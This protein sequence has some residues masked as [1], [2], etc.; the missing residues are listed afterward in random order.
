MKTTALIIAALLGLSGT[1]T[2]VQA[3]NNATSI[4]L[5]SI[6]M[7]TDGQMR[8]RINGEYLTRQGIKDGI[9]VLDMDYRQVKLEYKGR[10]IH[11]S[12]GEVWR[13]N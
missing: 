4:K 6:V 12:P 9:K 7:G 8:A 2:S 1:L 13:D 5:E 11:L 10:E 3:Q